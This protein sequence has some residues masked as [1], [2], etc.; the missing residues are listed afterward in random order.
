MYCTKELCYPASLPCISCLELSEVRHSSGLCLVPPGSC[1]MS[2]PSGCPSTSL[3]VLQWIHPL[4]PS[5]LNCIMEKK[6][7][8]GEGGKENS[9][10]Q[11]ISSA[12]QI[13][14]WSRSI[15]ISQLNFFNIILTATHPGHWNTLA[16]TCVPFSTPC[17]RLQDRQH[18]RQSIA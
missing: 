7:M 6:L 18:T 13:F 10:I 3:H 11:D 14:R 12:A 15:M 2:W 8:T 5:K 4:S 9:M 16:C 1:P 17:Q